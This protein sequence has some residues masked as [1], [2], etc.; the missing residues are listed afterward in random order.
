MNQR[1]LNKKL[2]NIQNNK[3]E[4]RMIIK[5]IRNLSKTIVE[6]EETRLDRLVQSNISSCEVNVLQAM[7]IGLS[8]SYGILQK[9]INKYKCAVPVPPNCITGNINITNNGIIINNSTDT[10]HINNNLM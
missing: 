5:E 4:A 9:I 1:L 8:Q 6:Q 7:Y 10:S 3:N 2:E